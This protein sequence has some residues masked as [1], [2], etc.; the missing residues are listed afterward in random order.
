MNPSG[1]HVWPRPTLLPL[2]LTSQPRCRL[3]TETGWRNI[4]V[5]HTINGVAVSIL[6][7]TIIE[8]CVDFHNDW[9]RTSGIMT[10]IKNVG[11]GVGTVLALDPVA[12]RDRD[13]LYGADAL[14]GFRDGRSIGFLDVFRFAIQLCSIH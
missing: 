7:C 6:P 13:F 14:Y 1:T 8:A 10:R 9:S 3:W 2:N 12:M 11:D 5:L 4:D